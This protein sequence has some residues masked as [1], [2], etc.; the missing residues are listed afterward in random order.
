[1]PAN[2]AMY[3]H[4]EA[5]RLMKVVGNKDAELMKLLE[6]V[7]DNSVEVSSASAR[8]ALNFFRVLEQAM[9]SDDEEIAKA[10]KAIYNGPYYM[11]IA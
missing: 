3:T 4:A 10:A 9:K 11:E 2:D 7:Q 8:N 6:E 1:M 5:E